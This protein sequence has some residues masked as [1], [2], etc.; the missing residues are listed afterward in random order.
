MS[1]PALSFVAMHQPLSLLSYG[2][3]YL[4]V[5]SR[6][7]R[8]FGWKCILFAQNGKERKGL[9]PF[10]VKLILASGVVTWER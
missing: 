9:V 10:F 1:L 5:L 6:R 4:F 2:T 3:E 7:G 8:D